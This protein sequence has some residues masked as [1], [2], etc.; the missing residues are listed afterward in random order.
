MQPIDILLI[1]LPRKQNPNQLE[2]IGLLRS[3]NE[4]LGLQYLA[5]N[6]LKNNFSVQIIDASL[7]DWNLEKLLDEADR[8]E[9]LIIG[10]SVLYQFNLS[11]AI[12]FIDS[13]EK[14]VHITAGGHAA[15]FCYEYLFDK[16]PNLNSVVRGEGEEIIVDLVR[17][18]KASKEWQVTEGIAFRDNNNEIKLTK[19]RQLI[20]NLDDYPP[21]TRPFL[22]QMI[23]KGGRE[24]RLLA[25]R[26]CYG[27]CTYCSISSFYRL[28]KVSWRGRSP[29]SIVDELKTI[30]KETGIDF[31]NFSDDDFIGPGTIGKRHAEGIARLIIKSGLKIRFGFN[32]RAA[33]V[34]EPL[35]LLLK[36]AGLYI[37]FIGIEAATDTQLEFLN[38]HCTVEQNEQ[39]LNILDSIDIEYKIGFIAFTPYITPEEVVANLKFILK[40]PPSKQRMWYLT[41]LLVYRGTA[42]EKKLL[43]DNL[44]TD[45]GD[46]YTYKYANQ[47]VQLIVDTIKEAYM[48]I[49][50][51]DI[52]ISEVGN[53]INGHEF[54][55]DLQKIIK[56]LTEAVVRGIEAGSISKRKILNS[57]NDELRALMQKL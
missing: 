26:G 52:K 41:E 4:P 40:L 8:F 14:N 25:S 53:K 54:R 5:A 49:K 36:E 24:A 11:L 51:A 18:I 21:P 48:L 57:F 16:C 42:L 43:A 55:K 44:L 2:P 15:T 1:N 7:D 50:P 34:D 3:D 9:P 31:F 33:D 56:L 38:K 29:E 47:E 30:N 17:K 22:N 23:Q 20:K 12:E 46:W 35:F 39:A 6:L 32:T 19:P 27:N 45:H 37:A 10:I 13:I 28:G